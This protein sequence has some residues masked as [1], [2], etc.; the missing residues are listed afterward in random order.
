[1]SLHVDNR[2]DIQ[3]VTLNTRLPLMT[4]WSQAFEDL[5]RVDLC[6]IVARVGHA[7]IYTAHLEGEKNHN[8]ARSSRTCKLAC[9]R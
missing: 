9:N 1:M 7:A 3:Y 6:K 8:L 5:K 4:Y 2:D